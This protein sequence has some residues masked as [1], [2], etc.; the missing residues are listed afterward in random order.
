MTV[1]TCEQCGHE[2]ARI[3]DRAG[4]LA[5]VVHP[6]E[7]KLVCLSK[8]PLELVAECPKCGHRTMVDAELLKHF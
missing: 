8:E 3:E 4:R 2:F 1:M 5:L 7:M 6:P